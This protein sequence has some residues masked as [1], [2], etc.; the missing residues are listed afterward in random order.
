MNQG[1]LT[2]LCVSAVVDAVASNNQMLTA[3]VCESNLT[4]DSLQQLT[5]EWTA[6]NHEN[7]LPILYDTAKQQNQNPIPLPPGYTSYLMFNHQSDEPSGSC[8]FIVPG[9]VTVTLPNGTME[10]WSALMN[11]YQALQIIT[12]AGNTTLAQTD[13]STFI[14]LYIAPAGVVKSASNASDGV[15]NLC[16]FSSNLVTQVLAALN[17]AWSTKTN[18]ASPEQMNTIQ[19]FLSMV[20]SRG[21]EEE[22]P[23]QTT[24]RNIVSAIQQNPSQ[25]STIAQ[26]GSAMNNLNSQTITLLAG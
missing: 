26:I 4:A 1:Q 10:A 15:S 11:P 9:G 3:Q 16:D 20:T 13:M 8:P 5:H 17:G 14:N 12:N 6:S 22:T 25:L 21:S 19:S 23:Y 7:A 2:Q 24:E 18:S